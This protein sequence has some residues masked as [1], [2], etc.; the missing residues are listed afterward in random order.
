MNRIPFI[1]LLVLASCAF[2]GCNHSSNTLESTTADGVTR[3]YTQTVTNT[4]LGFVVR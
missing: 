4:G 3:T 1:K 2:V